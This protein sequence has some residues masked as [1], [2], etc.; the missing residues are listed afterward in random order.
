MKKNFVVI[1]MGRFGF[2]VART[3]YEMGHDVLAVDSAQELVND[4]SPYVTHAV[5]ADAA[6]E[7]SLRALGLNNMDAAI[8]G[9]GDDI[10]ASIFVTILCKELGVNMVI[11]KAQD[12]LHGKVLSKIGADKVV[13]PERDMGIRVAQSLTSSNILEFI[14]LSDEHSI[15]EVEVPD[16]WD[17]CTIKD[18][19]LRKKHGVNVVAI[20][21]QDGHLNINPLGETVL[22]HK[23]IM[24]VI[25]SLDDIRNIEHPTKKK[26]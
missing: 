13:Y 26:K 7:K 4:I 9:M 11:S 2:S 24:V 8:I 15:V 25:G 21:S 3:L 14:G 18:L 6:D 5:Q 22:N 16:E 10:K 23:D 17:D 12:E 19:D 20:K 1:G